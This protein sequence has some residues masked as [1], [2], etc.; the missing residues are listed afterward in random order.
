M[1]LG[2]DYTIIGTIIILLVLYFIFSHK[3]RLRSY[4][5][6]SMGNINKDDIMKYLAKT[7][8]NINFDLSRLS[9]F[10]YDDVAQQKII[11]VEDIVYQFTSIQSNF[12]TTADTIDH[13]YIWDSYV[14]NSKPPKGKTPMDIKKRK[15]ALLF[16]DK[17]TCQRC[18]KDLNIDTLKIYFLKPLEDGGDYSFENMISVCSDCSRV[19]LSKDIKKTAQELELTEILYETI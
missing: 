16:R 12:P 19:L 17:H 4:L 15:E 8:P 9:E 3:E 18:S 6:T 7:Y 2:I 11:I 14:V 10:K 1:I 5:F 13:K